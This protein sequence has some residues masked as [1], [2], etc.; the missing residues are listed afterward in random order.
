MISILILSSVILMF[1]LTTPKH[2][3]VTIILSHW[4]NYRTWYKHTL[5]WGIMII[6]LLILNCS[7]KNDKIKFEWMQWKNVQNQ[8]QYILCNNIIVCINLHCYLFEQ[9]TIRLNMI[10]FDVLL[11]RTTTESFVRMPFS[12]CRNEKIHKSVKGKR[13]K[14][15]LKPKQLKN[16]SKTTDF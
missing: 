13:E 2:V 6:F 3:S 5:V 11:H 12:G 14:I 7:R 16:M 1:G 4:Y 15:E 9:H 8:C 10:L